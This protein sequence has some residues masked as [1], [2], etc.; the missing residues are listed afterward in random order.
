MNLVLYLHI[1]AKEL[2][3][4]LRISL[5]LGLDTNKQTKGASRV[6]HDTFGVTG[7]DTSKVL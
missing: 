4:D 7:G 3:E 1:N 5:M 6:V 2:K